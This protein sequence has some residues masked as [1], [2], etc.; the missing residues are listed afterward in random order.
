MQEEHKLTNREKV[1]APITSRPYWCYTCD[2]DGVRPNQK[3]ATCGAKAPG[4]NAK[5]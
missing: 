4:R 3:C 2:R 1:T 5:K